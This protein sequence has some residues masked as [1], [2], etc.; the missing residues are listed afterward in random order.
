MTNPREPAAWAP[1]AALVAL[2]WF[3]AVVAAAIA[4]LGPDPMGKLLLGI[5][6]VVLAF[7]SLFG[8]IARPRLRA[9][10]TGV[11]VRGL[12]GS[13]RWS[14]AEVNVRLTKTRRL[15]RE[16]HLVELDAENAA[17]PG[18]I[19]LGKLDLGEDPQDVAYTLLALR[20]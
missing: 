14:W 5:A 11:E 20:T 10:A 8:T 15:G 1:A 19:L 12:R 6:A 17:Q 4:I 2:G 16:V 9:D 18:L 7:V 13:V 3:L